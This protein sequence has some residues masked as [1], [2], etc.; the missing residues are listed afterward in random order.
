MQ[1]QCVQGTCAPSFLPP[2]MVGF[3]LKRGP[4][5]LQVT[6]V[7]GSQNGPAHPLAQLQSPHRRPRPLPRG[8]RRG[9]DNFTSGPISSGAR[10]STPGNSTRNPSLPALDSPPPT[11]TVIL[12]S[13]APLRSAPPRPGAAP[14]MVT[15][16]TP[17][18][19]YG[20][21]VAARRPCC[22]TAGAGPL[23]FFFVFRLSGP[24][25]AAVEMLP[26]G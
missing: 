22:R 13:S 9:G 15:S 19:R 25:G 2:E 1:C 5:L 6:T 21:G 17:S 10:A 4:T 23:F 18:I 14:P 26:E 3:C 8:S 11:R 24:S 12:R 7:D 20:Q 16:P